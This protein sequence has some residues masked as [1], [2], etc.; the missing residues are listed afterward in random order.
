MRLYGYFSW[1][2]VGDTWKREKEVARLVIGFFQSEKRQKSAYKVKEI[3]YEIG[4]TVQVE[5]GEVKYSID[6]LKS[7]GVFHEHGKNAV[8]LNK[9]FCN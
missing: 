1:K 5:N 4:K 9:D 7:H 2:Y 8:E 3:V 6:Y